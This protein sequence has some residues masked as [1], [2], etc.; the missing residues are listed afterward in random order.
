MPYHFSDSLTVQF[1][2]EFLYSIFV[3]AFLP[4][5]MIGKSFD[6][7]ISRTK[8]FAVIAV[9]RKK[10]RRAGLYSSS[11]YPR[12]SLSKTRTETKHFS[13]LYRARGTQSARRDE[14][15]VPHL[16]THPR[17]IMFSSLLFETT[18]INTFFFER[19]LKCVLSV[20]R[21]IRRYARHWS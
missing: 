11:F 13:W 5:L 17:H 2:L 14:F 6:T 10:E 12:S 15:Q 16:S 18:N 8:L 19:S 3:I 20:K 21:C 1:T 7:P 4:E 9:S